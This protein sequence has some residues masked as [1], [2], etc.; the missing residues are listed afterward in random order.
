MV[1]TD[2]RGHQINA[3]PSHFFICLMALTVTTVVAKLMPGHR[4]LCFPLIVVL[5]TTVVAKIMPAHYTSIKNIFLPQ[6][7]FYLTKLIYE[8]NSAE[9]HTGTI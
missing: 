5:V 3:R 9:A 7:A 1:V 2:N 4:S 8:G 6:T